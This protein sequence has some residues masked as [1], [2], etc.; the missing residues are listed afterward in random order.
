[1]FAKSREKVARLEQTRLEEGSGNM[2][3]PIEAEV[4]PI[5]SACPLSLTFQEQQR[6]IRATSLVSLDKLYF[7]FF[8]LL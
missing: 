3:S 2:E 4:I 6:Q 7:S 8:F 5:S 1:M